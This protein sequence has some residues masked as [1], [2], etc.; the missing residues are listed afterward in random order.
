MEKRKWKR[1]SPAL[2]EDLH[3]IVGEIAS[4]QVETEDGVGQGVTLVDGDGVGHTI[5][6]VEDDAGG[7]TG[8]VK[9]KHS[10]SSR[11]HHHHGFEK[12]LSSSVSLCSKL[13]SF[14][15]EKN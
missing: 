13:C 5:T 12:S 8:S 11:N 15:G 9:G 10:L 3:K 7:T 1:H 4:G 6:G 2:G 14:S